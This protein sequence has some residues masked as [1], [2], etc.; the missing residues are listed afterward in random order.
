MSHP[1]VTLCVTQPALS[2]ERASTDEEWCRLEP[3][4][5]SDFT[6]RCQFV[7]L[8]RS[9]DVVIGVLPDDASTL[10]PFALADAVT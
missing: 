9:E 1:R 3:E 10:I 2:G 6:R 4:F 8:P 5:S 7:F